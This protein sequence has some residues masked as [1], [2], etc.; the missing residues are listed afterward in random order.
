MSTRM[1]TTRLN[2]ATGLAM[3]G[4]PGWLGVALLAAAAWCYWG[5]APVAQQALLAQQDDTARLREQLTR[6]SASPDDQRPA[7]AQALSPEAAWQVLWQRLPQA[8]AG[9]RMQAALLASARQH[10]VQLGTVQFQGDVLPG[11]PGVW[12]QRMTLPVQAPYPALRAWINQVLQ[13]SAGGATVSLDALA[14]NRTD[15][16]SDVVKARVVWSLWWR[17]AP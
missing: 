7:D 6:A 13:A 10:G 12:R 4:L 14:V 5:E 16:M 15:V 17:A 3:L 8:E 2:W 1:R 9:V 11:M